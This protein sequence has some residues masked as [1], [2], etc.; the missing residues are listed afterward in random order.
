MSLISAILNIYIWVVVGILLFFLFAIAQFYEK[1]SGRRS[2]YPAFLIAALIL[3]VAAIRYVFLT[4][5]IVGDLWGDALRFIGSLVLGGFGLFLLRRM[6]G[7]R[8]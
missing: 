5:T 8:S 7:S 2:F 3:G 4:P 6:T 1:K